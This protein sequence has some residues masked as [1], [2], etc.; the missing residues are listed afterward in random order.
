[1][2]SNRSFARYISLSILGMLG[3]SGTI[4]ADT[5]FVSHRLGADGLAALNI[6]ISIFGLI[7]G[8]GM[9]L[10]VGGATRYTILRSQG[11]GRQADQAFS[12]AFGAALATGLCF[13][14]AGLGGA[15]GIARALGANREIL[16]LCT[17]YLRTVLCFA[18]FF[19][20]NH[21]F[22]AFLRNDGA[23]Q[24]AM[25]V[26]LTGSLANILLDYLFVYPLELGI[27]GAALATGLAP[28]LGILVASLH[29]WR[30]RNGFHLVP[31]R[32]RPGALARIAGPGLASFVN[33][34]SSC[35][36]L[37]VFNRL[38][39]QAEGN[40]GVAAYGIVA[41]LALVALAVFTGIAQGLQPLL[42]DAYGR[43]DARQLD[44]L[45]RLGRRLAGGLGVGICALA[46]AAAPTLAGWFNSEQNVLLQSLAEEGLR[47]YFVG[48][49]FVGGNHLIA[50]LLST[51]GRARTAFG[52]SVFRGCVGI[53]AA[54]VLLGALFGMTGIWMAY[55]VVELTTLLMGLSR[56]T[57][58]HAAR[59]PG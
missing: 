10:G 5:F 25:A 30:G 18:P 3:S 11:H 58:R 21:L 7:N 19:V 40:T 56:R 50:A 51:T 39:L 38:I 41:N 44:R 22:M 42:S 20:L 31:V 33:E 49:L 23:P 29:L 57:D 26:M 45:C 13:W 43:G 28:V 12:L 34:F 24:L 17:T 35:V 14:M 37:V 32:F 54:A 27:F 48:F 55:P 15:G 16:P 9:L 1:M 6:A 8:L 46:W 53:T 59:L 2:N 36:V 47:I 52:L 4:L